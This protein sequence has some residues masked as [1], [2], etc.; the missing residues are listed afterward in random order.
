MIIFF[1]LQVNGDDELI[2][3]SVLPQKETFR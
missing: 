2:V 3:S 1:H